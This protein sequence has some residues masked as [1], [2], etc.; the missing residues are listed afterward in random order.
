LQRQPRIL[1]ADD[2][3]LFLGI[4]RALLEQE[5]YIVITAQDGVE[6]LRKITE[7][8]PDAVLL[9]LFMPGMTGFE[10]LRTLRT[11]AGYKNFRHLPVLITSVARR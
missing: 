11:N 10:V 5:G 1:V 7:E 4:A 2:A 3:E 6:A 8:H 9:D